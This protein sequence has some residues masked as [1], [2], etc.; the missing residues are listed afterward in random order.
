MNIQETL[1][2]RGST[3]GDFTHNSKRS[4]HIKFAMHLAENW[5]G[6]IEYK[7]EALEMIAHKIGRI[8]EGDSDY[9][10]HW[11]DIAGYATLVADRC[12]ANKKPPTYVE[13]SDYNGAINSTQ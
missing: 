3:H 8:L 2:E 10:D 5:D 12:D 11:H 1:K 6:L 4:Q 7:K 9:S 13:A